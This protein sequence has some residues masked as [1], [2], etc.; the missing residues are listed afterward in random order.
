[1]PDLNIETAWTCCSNTSWRRFIKDY[2]VVWG[3]QPPWADY[4]YGW[5]CTCQGFKF[6]KKCKH[7]EECKPLRCG[8]N[9]EL[10]PTAV[11]ARGEDGSP[12]CPECGGEVTAFRVGV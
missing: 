7:V 9:S 11:P 12:V 4:Q 10:E 5:T 3:V 8:W 1:V 2:E 6:R